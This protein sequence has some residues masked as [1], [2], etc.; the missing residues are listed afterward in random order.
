MKDI[1]SV[2]LSNPFVSITL[3]FLMAQCMDIFR[4]PAPFG[5]LQTARRFLYIFATFEV[6]FVKSVFH[7]QL[8]VNLRGYFI[9][10]IIILYS[11]C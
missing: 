2:L 10:I 1:T 11:V 5:S 4:H 3:P 6:F 9:I 7:F 8:L